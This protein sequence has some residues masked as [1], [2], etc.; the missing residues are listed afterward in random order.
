MTRF[1]FTVDLLELWQRFAEKADAVGVPPFDLNLDAAFQEVLHPDGP[2]SVCVGTAQGSYDASRLRVAR[3]DLTL[4]EISRLVSE[5]PRI[6]I[7]DPESYVVN[8]DQELGLDVDQGIL[9]GHPHW[10][11]IL[12]GS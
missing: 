12:K 3:G 5:E 11:P 8:N 9:Q 2:Y 7:C 10:D 4:K 6:F 1:A